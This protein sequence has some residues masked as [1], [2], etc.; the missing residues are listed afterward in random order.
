MSTIQK[1]S[2]VSFVAIAKPR[3]EHSLISK[4]APACNRQLL[5][6]LHATFLPDADWLRVK[7]AAHL[8]SA[9]NPL[10]DRWPNQETFVQ[11]FL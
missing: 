11:G 7:A 2:I 3:F 9:Q 4:R 8:F 10:H 5:S 1:W 6:Q